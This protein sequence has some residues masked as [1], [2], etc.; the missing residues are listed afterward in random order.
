MTSQVFIKQNTEFVWFSVKTETQH[1]LA[2]DKDLIINNIS[3]NRI[4]TRRSDFGRSMCWYQYSSGSSI[5]SPLSYATNI[6]GG[7]MN[8]TNIWSI[9][10][11]TQ[12]GPYFQTSDK[13]CGITYTK[14]TCFAFGLEYCL[15]VE[16]FIKRGQGNLTIL[17]NDRFLRWQNGERRTTTLLV[18][19]C[20][21][22]KKTLT[23]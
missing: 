7:G 2:L 13:I 1:I 14:V 4:E 16:L 8:N 22:L 10:V 9:E 19:A 3:F 12:L 17:D 18:E 5:T 6:H 15:C 21:F 23:V 20:C 11:L